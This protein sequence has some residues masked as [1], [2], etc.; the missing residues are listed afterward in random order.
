MIPKGPPFVKRF[1]ST[2]KYGPVPT[3]LHEM[4]SE[5]GIPEKN[6]LVLNHPLQKKGIFHHTRPKLEL[7]AVVLFGIIL[8]FMHCAVLEFHRR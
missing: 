5:A 3:F 4:L 8:E 2:E 1:N 6:W 7:K